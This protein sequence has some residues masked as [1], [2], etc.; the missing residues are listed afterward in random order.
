[1]T[2]LEITTVVVLQENEATKIANNHIEK[3]K[4]L[5]ENRDLMV[6]RF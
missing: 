3:P 2:A 4:T 5:L 6:N 1:V